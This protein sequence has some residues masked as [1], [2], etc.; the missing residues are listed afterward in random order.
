M[1]AQLDGADVIYFTGGSPEHLH[2][3]LARSPLLDAVKAANAAGA[4]WA[5]SSAGAMVLGSGDADGRR[6]GRPCQPGRWT[7]CRT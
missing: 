5:G 6:P 1:A 3:V 4:V 2:S 7:W